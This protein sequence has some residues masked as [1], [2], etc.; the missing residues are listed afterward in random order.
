MKMITRAMATVGILVI[1]GSPVLAA[2]GAREV[3]SNVLVWFFL[4]ICALIIFLQ[5]MPVLSLTFAMIKGLTGDKNENPEEE[6][7]VAI[8][9]YK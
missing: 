9:K 5:I 8:S 6:V 2:T 3:S 1:V 4:G 7:E